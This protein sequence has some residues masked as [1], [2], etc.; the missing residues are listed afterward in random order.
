MNPLSMFV[1]ALIDDY[2]NG[3][4]YYDTLITPLSDSI[5]GQSNREK[6]TKHWKN[7]IIKTGE[8]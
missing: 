7:H 1:G 8:M 4:E 3:I 2:A 5:G 6:H